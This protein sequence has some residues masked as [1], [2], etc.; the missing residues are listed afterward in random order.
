MSR[1]VWGSEVE[2][3]QGRPPRWLRVL[4]TGASIDC[5]GANGFVRVS[6]A[7]GRRR[8]LFV[9]DGAADIPLV[10]Y[11]RRDLGPRSLWSH[12]LPYGMDAPENGLRVLRDLSGKVIGYRCF[13]VA[14]GPDGQPLVQGPSDPAPGAF[15]STTSLVDPRWP[16]GSPRRSF[17]SS[18]L[19]GW[20]LPGH[21]LDGYARIGD[22]ALLTYQGRSVW[23][24]CFDSGNSGSDRCEISVRAA[25]ALGIPNGGRDGGV[26]SGLRVLVLLGSRSTYGALRPLSS[27]TEIQVAGARA[28]RAAGFT[29]DI[30]C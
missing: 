8:G 19:G 3:D 27:H 13:G 2:L 14:A 1:I 21:D 9:P 26:A 28:A 30:P 20:V 29:G 5:D 25:D 4:S 12:D 16:P 18:A 11:D 10:A 6:A 22:L 15:V 7:E 24:Q 23:A 17:D